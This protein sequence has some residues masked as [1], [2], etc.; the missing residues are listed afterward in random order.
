VAAACNG[1]VTVSEDEIGA[2]VFYVNDSYRPF[3]GKC[4]VVFRN[5]GQVKEQFSFRKGLLHGEALTWYKN[6]QLRRKGSYYKGQISGKW[7]FWDEQGN[8][9]MEAYYSHD[10]LSGSYVELYANTNDQVINTD[11]R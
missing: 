8:K 5:T 2:D 11:H 4:S 9:I 7:E 3:S 1:K 6:G 10:N